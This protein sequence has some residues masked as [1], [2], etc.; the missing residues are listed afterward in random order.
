MPISIE[1]VEKVASLAKLDFS[2]KE[3][4][5]LVKELNKIV[6]YVQKLNELDT[7]DVEP[8]SHVIEL[9]NVMRDDKVELWLSQEK[10]F[11]NAPAQKGG[12]FSVPK[13]IK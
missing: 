6:S 9:K 7:N 4:N 3:K 8:T 10:A 2:N 1:D 12:F 13:V 11:E 5:K